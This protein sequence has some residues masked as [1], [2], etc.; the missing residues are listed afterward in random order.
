MA[1]SEYDRWVNNELAMLTP[2]RAWQPD[3]SAR[4]AEVNVKR[5]ADRSRRIRATG[6]VVAIAVAFVSL[7]ITRAFAARCVE[8]CLSVTTSVSQL[9]NDDGP[10]AHAPR[11]TGFAI[12]NL[13]PDLAGVDRSGAPVSLLALRGHIV[14]VNF[15]ATWCQP[16]KAEIPELNDIQARFGTNGVDVIGVSIDD[17]GWSVIDPF[18][19]Q[20]DMQYRVALADDRILAAFGGVGNVP[21]TFVIGRDGR[22]LIK[23]V[24][25][26]TEGNERNQILQLLER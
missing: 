21:T 17:E 2:D 3:A 10:E 26:L 11:V 16:C 7:P 18:A 13:S 6:A 15:W 14:V 20:Q 5:L 1:N 12:G 19:A 9:W 24:G 8:A 22:I 25:I 4:L 23:R